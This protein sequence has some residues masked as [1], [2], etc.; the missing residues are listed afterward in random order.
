M[1]WFNRILRKKIPDLVAWGP[2]YETG[3]STIDAQH[4]KLFQ[5]TNRLY[6]ACESEKA[7]DEFLSALQYAAAYAKF[8]LLA[9][10]TYMQKMRMSAQRGDYVREHLAEHERFLLAV[11]DFTGNYKK[12]EADPI[13]FVR[14]LKNWIFN[15]IATFDM[16]LTR[17]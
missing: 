2:E 17:P 12:G 10:E 5:I 16:E 7:N 9:E 3:Q 8:H 1:R 6:K 15:H 4:R 11:V 14:F 13:D